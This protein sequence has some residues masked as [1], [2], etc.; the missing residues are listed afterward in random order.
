MV[1]IAIKD[2]SQCNYSFGGGAAASVSR[3]GEEQ[4]SSW[5]CDVS[6]MRMLLLL[7][8]RKRKYDD[9]V[10]GKPWQQHPGELEEDN[11][12]KNNKVTIKV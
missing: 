7:L 9:K 4:N 5:K 8:A 3:G 12:D 6:Q 10:V 2:E 1:K 11:R